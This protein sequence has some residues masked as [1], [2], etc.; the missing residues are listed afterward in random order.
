M[1]TLLWKLI[2]KGN[3]KAVELYNLV[4][5]SHVMTNAAARNP[6]TVKEPR[7]KTGGRA[8]MR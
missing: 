3:D 2:E 1:R 6:D 8:V 5:D 4:D 7:S